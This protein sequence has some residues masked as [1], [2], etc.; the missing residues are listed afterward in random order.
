MK[1]LITGVTGNLGSLVLEALLNKVPK[2]SIAVMLRS[3]KNAGIFSDRGI[4]VRIGS[5]DDTA[6]MISAF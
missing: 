5:Y 6:S 3:E 2:E 1:I 4:E